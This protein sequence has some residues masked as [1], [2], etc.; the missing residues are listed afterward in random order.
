MPN[1]CGNS[2][3]FYQKSKGTA[4]LE[5]FYADIQKYQDYREPET[6]ASSS[7]IGHWLESNRIDMSSLETR[8]FIISC[9]LHD[10]HV[11]IDMQTA[12][13]P[14]TEVWGLMADKYDLS[15]VYISEECGCEVYVNTDTT[16]MFFTTRYQLNYFEIED[17]DINMDT[18]EEYHDLLQKIC[19][20]TMYFDSWKE[21]VEIFTPLVFDFEDIDIL[22]ERLEVLGISVYRYDYE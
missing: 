17:L 3:A 18:L 15:Y 10:D 9:E 8:C 19:K 16:G 1:W 12:W 4:M 11:R 21:V 22:N 6:N 5:A 14:L 2:I 7:W 13:E 20:E